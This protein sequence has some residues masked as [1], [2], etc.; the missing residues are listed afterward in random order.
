MVHDVK[1]ALKTRDKVARTHN[2]LMGWIQDLN[3]WLHTENRRVLGEQT[4]PKGKRL[5]LHIDLD[6]LVTIQNT[7]NIIFTRLTQGTVKVLEDPELQKG[8]TSETESS[9]SGS[10]ERGECKTCPHI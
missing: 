5:I 7:G 4:E 10:E 2:K 6:S 8:Q 9:D 1:I 3:A